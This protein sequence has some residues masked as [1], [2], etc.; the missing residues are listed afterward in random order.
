MSDNILQSGL[1]QKCFRCGGWHV[2]LESG[3]DVIR[4]RADTSLSI[5]LVAGSLR[6]GAISRGR[7]VRQMTIRCAKCRSE[8]VL[9][10][11]DVTQRA[12]NPFRTQA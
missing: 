1:E 10:D 8:A 4:M 3:D 6:L 11:P 5:V 9:R 12:L 2:L 7:L